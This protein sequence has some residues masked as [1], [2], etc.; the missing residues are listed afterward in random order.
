VA[1]IQN[2][3]LQLR[4]RQNGNPFKADCQHSKLQCETREC[5]PAQRSLGPLE[6]G[7]KMGSK[8]E[9][10]NPAIAYSTRIAI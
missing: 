10:S 3:K 4:V 1:E 6:S 2:G 9:K 5:S 7:G 8:I